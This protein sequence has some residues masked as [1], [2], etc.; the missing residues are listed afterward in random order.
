MKQK[1]T[2]ILSLLLIAALLCGALPVS[3]GATAQ[4]TDVPADSW[5]SAAVEDMA[6]RGVISGKTAHT[7]DPN[8]T[9]TRAEF[10]AMISKCALT[11]RDLN[12]YDFKS[13]FSDVA[14]NHWGKKSINWASEAGIISGTGGGKFNPAGKVTRQDIA[15]MVS[16]FVRVTGR[17][18]PAVTGPILF[19]DQNEISGY[20][21]DSVTL[22]QRGGV[23]STRGNMRFAPK[24]SA[25]RA[26]AAVILSNLLKNIRSSGYS[27]IRKRLNGT[28]YRA[29]EFDP[30]QFSAG[31]AMG[32]SRA[33]GGEGVR[34][35]VSRTGARIAVNAAFFDMDSYE[36]LGTIIDSGRIITTFDRFAPAKSA[37]TMDA[38]GK[39]SV[40]NFATRISATV[41]AA[42][43]TPRTMGSMMV[44]RRPGEGDGSRIIFTSDWGE[45]LAFTAGFAAVVD[46]SGRVTAVYRDQNVSI[47]KEGYVLALRVPRNDAFEAAFT[48]GAHMELSV[49][50]EG[51]DT[52][53]IILS[54]GVGPK[55][56]EYGQPYG[57]SSTYYQEGFGTLDTGLGVRRVCIGIRDDNHLV[58]MTAVGS[59]AEMSDIMTSLDC[60]SAVNLDG[61]GSTNLYVDGQWLYGPQDRMLNNMLYF[62]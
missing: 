8:G 6:Q 18:L 4:F 9:L 3:A 44:N 7:F 57:N 29:V 30:S 62:K 54:L 2:R 28:S 13:R 27:I 32:S 60:E 59:L 48:V 49:E 33:R 23:I 25:T 21:Q 11:S 20:A 14:N 31:V 53:E 5:Y 16:Q 40:Q 12:E 52:Q 26:E 39:F 10:A 24:G 15:V 45:S 55:I 22:C 35:M 58:I 47:P 50:Y 36:A 38:S 51:A 1:L 19:F 17:Q 43:G 41:T 56:V 61:G 42:D 34:S 37:I 46:A